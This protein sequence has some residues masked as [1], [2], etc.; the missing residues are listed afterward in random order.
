MY[1]GV[2]WCMCWYSGR[3]VDWWYLC[4]VWLYFEEIVGL[5]VV[6]FV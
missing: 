3:R 2:L 4:V 6:L 5:C 1:G